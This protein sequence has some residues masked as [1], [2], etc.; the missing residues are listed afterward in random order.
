[1]EEGQKYRD[2]AVVNV[3]PIDELQATL[4]ELIHLPTGAMVM[5]IENDDPENL[6]CLSFKTLPNSSDGAAHILEHTVLCGSRKYPVKDPFFSMSRR[7]LNTFMNAMTGS[8]FT[9]YPAATQVE[10]DF[11]NLL[12]VYLDATF[13][14]LLKEESFLQEGHYLALSDPEN[15]NSPLLFKGIVYNEMKGA[16]SSVDSR[17]WHRMTSL[18]VP[19]LPYAHNSGG[20]PK[21]IPN[22]T[23]K[24]LIEFHEAFYHPSRCLFYFYGNFPLEK[25]LDFLEEHALKG[26]HKLPP[27]DGIGHQKRFT[28]PVKKR[29]TYPVSETDDLENKVIHSFGWLTTPLLNQEDVL[30]LT[31]LDS[32]LMDTD[33]SPLKKKL[34]ETKL[35]IQADCYLD[36]EMSEVPLMMIF[37]GCQ[38]E[39]VDELEKA[40]FDI[41]ATIA[42]EGIPFSLVEASI[43]QLEL[44][45]TEI[46]GDH[47]PFG[48]T[49]FWRSGLAKQHG[50]APE[51]ALV[52]HSLFEELVKKA[53]DPHFFTPLIEKYLLNNPHMVRLSY[54]PDP[55]LQA[56]ETEEEI[57]RLEEI[58]KGLSDRELA[59]I[60][61]QTKNLEAFQASGK[62]E[63]LDC[64]PKV[65]L[66]DIPAE[67]REFP[68]AE[69]KQKNLEIFHHDVF[70]NHI[71]YADLLF[72]LPN[73]SPEELLDFQ[74]FLTFWPELGVGDRDYA[75]NLEYAH[76]HTGG[77]GAYSSL[78]VQATDPTNCRPSIQLRGKA[79][80]RKI[81]KL[82]PLLKEMVTR[83]RFDEK[84]RI[85]ELIKK[86]ATAKQNRLPQNALRYAAQLTFC[87]N[88]IPSYIN[89]LTHGLDFYTHVQSLAAGLP[90]SLDSF[91]QRL[92]ALKDKLLAVGT[93]QL[94]L[95]CD[96]DLYSLVDKEGFF[97]L[98]NLQTRS[99]STWAPDY[100]LPEVKDQAR[101]IASPVAFTAQGYKTVPYH[102]E[103]APALLVA[104][105]LFENKVLHHRIREQGGA[106]GAGASYNPLY[107]NFYFYSYRDPHLAHTLRTFDQAISDIAAKEF[108]E[109]DLEEAKLGVIQQF[110]TP[111]S[112][113][114]RASAAYG[115]HRGGKNRQMRQD[116]RD[117]LL[118]LGSDQ[119]TAAIKT[120]LMEQSSTVATFAG[121]ELLDK[122]LPLVDHRSLEILPIS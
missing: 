85:A 61:E 46:G 122:E 95:S 23:Y 28:E 35:C 39:K 76:A 48:L 93:P 31:I 120:H 107:G 20:D 1:M 68:L 41:L 29:E 87:A 94:V 116:F 49:L 25:H 102:H 115:W 21:E 112:P 24:E 86:L 19:D 57:K 84:E 108:N 117:N 81:D 92:T 63:P 26:V 105:H 34:L 37:R 73:L 88:S 114:Y 75:E 80:T 119:V 17:L 101:V 43:H 66:A 97:G 89:Q 78:Y 111:T 104:T 18:L 90:G 22:L 11:Y 103:D 9:C 71:V 67:T 113:G 12:E 110:D 121:Q 98:P 5:H 2:F 51:H 50:C 32:V 54:V 6:F 58:R 100:I 4:R 36:V 77:V 99:G 7:S 44:S 118:A 13:H 82:F 27:I 96:E 109:N 38:E 8:D 79:L 56:K 70:T 69:H 74:L 14:P 40:L 60:V 3:Q 33:A 64:L 42:K 91:I 72:D 16:L 55:S 53:K 30:A 65:T 62:K 83:P 52:V 45:R 59:K 10:K 15:M 47:S 106:Y